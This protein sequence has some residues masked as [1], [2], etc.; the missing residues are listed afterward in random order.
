MDGVPAHQPRQALRRPWSNR[1][2]TG[3][4]FETQA[5]GDE[6][7]DGGDLLPRHVEL[8][9]DLVHSEILKVVDPPWRRAD[10]PP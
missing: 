5:V 8:L 6:L 4:D 9:R 2:S 1:T 7:E 10:G 3:G